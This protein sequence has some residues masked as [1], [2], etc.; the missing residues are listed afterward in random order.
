MQ[1]LPTPI[2]GCFVVALRRFPDERGSFEEVYNRQRYR[3]QDVPI[4]DDWQQ[5]NCSRSVRNVVRGI[6][7]A[8]FAKLVTCLR[9]RVFDIVVDMRPDSPTYR[10]WHAE[11]L[12]D[13]NA[14]QIYVPPACGHGFMGL[15]EDNLVVY[16]QTATYD[17]AV[18]RTIHWRDPRLAIPWPAAERYV[19]SARDEQAPGLG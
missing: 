8:P 13:E 17:P 12:S 14:R 1:L 7:I 18:E 5:V 6:H 15:D 11:E 19:V 4:Q 16:L 10:R 2:H 9:G 3:A